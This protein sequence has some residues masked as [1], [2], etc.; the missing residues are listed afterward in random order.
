M[1]RATKSTPKNDEAEKPSSNADGTVISW[2]YCSSSLS[3]LRGIDDLREEGSLGERVVVLDA[4]ER[5]RTPTQELLAKVVD[6]GA[7]APYPRSRR[8]VHTLEIDHDLVDA[9][10]VRGPGVHCEAL[11][12]PE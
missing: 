10:D 1:M 11:V 2:R 3:I 9:C 12:D 8:P 6:E 7:V 4:F 5:Q